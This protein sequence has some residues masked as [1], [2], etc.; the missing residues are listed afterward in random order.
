MK[1]NDQ[2][3]LE[4]SGGPVCH[5]VECG[6]RLRG[7]DVADPVYRQAITSAGSGA[8]AALDA[9]QYLSEQGIQDE[10][11]QFADDLMAELWASL[12]RRTRA[13]RRSEGVDT[14]S[15]N[16]RAEAVSMLYISTAV[17]GSPPNAAPRRNVLPTSLTVPGQ[18]FWLFVALVA[19]RD[20]APGPTPGPTLNDVRAESTDTGTDGDAHGRVRP[21]L[22]EECRTM[23]SVSWNNQR[24][25]PSTTTT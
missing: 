5:R 12:M 14:S 8:M 9:E 1:T 17:M 15:A 10:S 2:G 22:R 21:R 23:A 18:S 19:R 20:G 3:Y 11:E 13:Q 4:L 25:S 7:G 6:G 24:A 16:A